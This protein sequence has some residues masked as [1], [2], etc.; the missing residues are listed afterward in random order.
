MRKWHRWLSAFFA[1]I[2]IWVAITGVL[3]YAGVWWPVDELTTEQVAAQQPPEDFEC[4]EGWRCSPPRFSSGIR[5]MVGTFHHL[6]SGETFGLAGEIIVLLSGVA[7]VFFSISGLWM[8]YQ[9]WENRKA[10]GLKKGIFW[11]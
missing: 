11:D 2:M 1:I 5:S 3:H 8:Y 4:P 10:R 7:L 9:M 6:H